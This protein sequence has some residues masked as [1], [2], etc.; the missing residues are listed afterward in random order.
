M[1]PAIIAPVMGGKPVVRGFT[2]IWSVAKRFANLL[3]RKTASRAACSGHS[4][5]GFS[6]AVFIPV[7]FRVRENSQH[8]SHLAVAPLAHQRSAR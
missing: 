6:S 3:S 8:S 4:S 1:A 7:E 5:V 2:A